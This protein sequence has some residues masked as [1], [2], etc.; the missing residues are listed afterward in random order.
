MLTNCIIEES[1]GGWLASMTSSKSLV[2]V[3]ACY[4]LGFSNWLIIK[5]INELYGHNWPRMVTNPLWLTFTWSVLHHRERNRVCMPMIEL[6]RRRVIHVIKNLDMHQELRTLFFMELI[7]LQ[8]KAGPFGMTMM[9]F[10]EKKRICRSEILDRLDPAW[11]FK[12]L[13]LPP[14]NFSSCVLLTTLNLFLLPQS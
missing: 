10:N 3:C 2:G 9:I 1:R 14:F 6:W 11:F 12:I 5:W 13:Q 4:V 7:T 8:M